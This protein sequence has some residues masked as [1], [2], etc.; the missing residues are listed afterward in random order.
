MFF[1]T[2]PVLTVAALTAA[3]PALTASALQSSPKAEIQSTY[4]KIAKAF[5]RKDLNVATSYFTADYVSIDDKGESKSAEQIRQ[6]YGPLLR[7]V[8]V[9]RSRISIQ[10][11]SAQGTQA[12][13]LVKQRSDLLYGKSKLVR[14]DTFRDTWIKT[15]EGWRIKQSQTLSVST[16]MD[17]RPVSN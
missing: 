16:T 9:T 2:I 11:F 3:I 13:A 5:E 1:R 17:G 15:A 4:N 12:S 14:E 6:Q 8:K 7:M 10:T